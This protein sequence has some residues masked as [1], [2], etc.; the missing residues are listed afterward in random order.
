MCLAATVV[1]AQEEVRPVAERA[2]VVTLEAE[3]PPAPAGFQL[4][5]GGLTQHA[6]PQQPQSLLRPRVENEAVSSAQLMRYKTAADYPDYSRYYNGRGIPVGEGGSIP[7]SDF[8]IGIETGRITGGGCFPLNPSDPQSLCLKDAAGQ[9][10]MKQREKWT[11]RMSYLKPG[12]P[13]AVEVNIG[14][15]GAWGYV[16]DD[17]LVWVRETSEGYRCFTFYSYECNFYNF[18]LDY[19]EG[20]VRAFR[21]DCSHPRGAG[22][23]AQIFYQY[24]RYKIT[25]EIPAG[26][27]EWEPAT[28]AATATRLDRP[29]KEIFGVNWRLT[30]DESALAVGGGFLRAAVPLRHID[31]YD[32]SVTNV[33]GDV[34]TAIAPQEGR[35]I[36]NSTECGQALPNVAFTGT[37]NYMEQSGGHKHLTSNNTS[38]PAGRVSNAP[39]SFSGTTDTTGRWEAPFTIKAGEFAGAYEITV[40]TDNLLPGSTPPL[41]FTSKRSTL[42]V[43]FPGM[44]R[45]I[46]SASDYLE[47]TGYDSSIPNNCETSA[48][49]NHKDASYY[50]SLALHDFIR[51]LPGV[52]QTATGSS[53]KIRVNDMSLPQGG[54]F[55]IDGNW[56]LKKH[57]SHRIGVDVDVNRNVRMPNGT[58][59]SLTADEILEFQEA[60]RTEL[61]GTRINEPSIH[62]RLPATMIDEVVGGF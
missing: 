13:N 8:A 14:F 11:F 58:L 35:L 51:K 47:M 25:D 22:Y 28:V 37:I 54:A 55:D 52:F 31:K 10:V 15:P 23:R 36:V 41:P 2:D 61:K 57:I 32:T 6:L 3:Q 21:P 50:G 62:F 46:P 5:P 56:A 19:I 26:V 53:G 18:N 27:N 7:R 40:K 30:P 45:F 49:D 59:V 39:T 43:G 60:V 48:C 38:P 4:R 16:G 34:H 17:E 24:S 1:A 12:D 42:T 29:G 33:G 44:W 20:S 9:T